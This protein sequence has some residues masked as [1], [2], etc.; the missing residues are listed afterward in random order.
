M[1]IFKADTFTSTQKKQERYSDFTTNLNI[2]PGSKDVARLTN[3]EAIKRSVKNLLLTKKGERLFQPLI[4]SE[5]TSLLFEPISPE[6]E[7]ILEEYIR[8]VIENFEPRVKIA[9]LIVSGQLD[10]NAY[11]VTLIFST[12]NTTQPT[13]MEFLLSRIR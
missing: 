11:T 5:I 3:E 12:I 13:L 9:N 8:N 4:G 7:L 6:T 10:Q 1:A 2:H